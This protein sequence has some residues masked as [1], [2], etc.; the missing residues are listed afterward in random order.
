MTEDEFQEDRVCFVKGTVERSRD[1][2]GL[3]LTR[4]FSP[5]Q[6]QQELTRARSDYLS[7][8]AEYNKAQYSL[9][10]AVGVDR[11]SSSR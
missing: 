2:P 8:V 6:A 10:R 1:E 3:I 4:V 7:A 5:A 11:S 9:S